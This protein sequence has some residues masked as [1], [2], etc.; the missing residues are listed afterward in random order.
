[1]IRI[2]GLTKRYGDVAVVRDVSFDVAAGEAVALWGPNGAGKSTI[3]RCLLGSTRF[4]GTI[5]LGGLD[6]RRHGK[7]TK[8]LVGYVPQHLAFYDELDVAETVALSC[9]LRRSPIERG[10]ELLAEV[11]L[12]DHW[13]KRVGA[14]SG[15]M[16]QRLGIALAL[17][18][19]PAILLLD[20]PTSSLDVAA[21]DSVLGVFE[22]LRDDRRAVLLTSHHLEEVGVLA[23]RVL[24]MDA[25]EVRLEAGPAE[26]AA[27]LGLRAWLHVVV[28]RGELSRAIEVLDT[29]GF[30]VRKNTNGLVVE[31]GAGN[32]AEALGSLHRAGVEVI[33]V[34]VWR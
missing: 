8:R 34:D 3:M 27:Q 32:K 28:D 23:D 22:R 5:E 12:A 9:R 2:H 20:E 24:A 31:V 10:R 6:V 30:L 13:D 21:R 1:M 19:D 17:V 14:L 11:G 33:D 18:A 7:S 26:L 4:E 15:G 25:G 29:A 16:Q